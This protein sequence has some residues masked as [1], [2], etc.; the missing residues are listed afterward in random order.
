MLLKGNADPKGAIK[1]IDALE[2]VCNGEEPNSV[3]E[4]MELASFTGEAPEV[5]LKVYKWIWGQEDCNYP[6]GEGREMSMKD[7]RKLR[8][9]LKDK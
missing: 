5:L 9:T 8:E 4:R 7:I 1:I 3:L 6:N 2:S